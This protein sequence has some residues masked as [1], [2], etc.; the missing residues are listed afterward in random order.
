MIRYDGV[1]FVEDSVNSSL[2]LRHCCL[3]V[4]QN[5]QFTEAV[6][7][8]VDDSDDNASETSGGVPTDTEEDEEMPTVP[9]MPATSQPSASTGALAAHGVRDFSI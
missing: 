6:E 3:G 8:N 5:R 7:M 2:A 1:T 4:R 9:T